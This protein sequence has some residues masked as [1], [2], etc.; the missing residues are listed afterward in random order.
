MIKKLRMKLI[1]ASMVSLLLVLLVI[2]GLVGILNYR[3]IVRD[4]DN[5]LSVLEENEGKFPN[6]GLHKKLRQKEMTKEMGEMSPE[7]PYESRYFS[8]SLD[9]EGNVIATDIEKVARIDETDA[10]HM[11]KLFGKRK[12]KEDLQMNTGMRLFRQTKGNGSFSLIA[13]EVFLRFRILCLRWQV[14]LPWGFSQ[15]LYL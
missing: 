4:A 15:C 12:V 5:I 3:K 8:V 7:V 14:C 11:Q 6:E 9:Q 13:D 2:E 10:E 1:V